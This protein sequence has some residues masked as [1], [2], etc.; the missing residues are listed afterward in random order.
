MRFSLP[1][2][3]DMLA[4]ESDAEELH[5]SL[6]QRTASLS[7]QPESERMPRPNRGPRLKLNQ[8]SIYEIHWTESGRSKRGSTGTSDR[9]S[10][11]KVLGNFLLLEKREQLKEAND[12]LLVCTVLGDEHAPAADYWHEHVIPNVIDKDSARYAYA[13]LLKHFGHLAVADIMPADVAAYVD[14]RRSGRI[15]NP[16]VNHTISRELSVLNAA[17]NHAVKAKRLPKADQ[18]FIKLPGTSPP[19]DRWLSFD[20]ADAL[21]TAALD[22]VD[23]HTPQGT[24]PR[25]YRFV[26]LALNTAGRKSALLGLQRRQVSLP[27]GMIHLNPV[28]RAQTK[29]HRP[30]VPIS[31]ALRPALERMLAEIADEPGAYLLGHPG[32]IRTAFENAV[33]RAGLG[34]DVTPHTLR[35]TKATWMAQAGVSMFDIAGV[36][37]D[38]VDTVTKTYAHHHPD[39][40]RSAI[41]AGRQTA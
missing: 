28:G 21:L 35:H 16:S 10:A 15:G 12:K 7:T 22:P 13:K 33:A 39:F 31:N 40:L 17:I 1:T 6:S 27:G 19:R 37:G 30:R 24:L 36:L 18:P 2:L 8:R 20:E 5:R 34:P 23:P 4:T 25:V 11:E 26:T 29:K 38:S 3:S 9:R 32:C 41:N 14:A